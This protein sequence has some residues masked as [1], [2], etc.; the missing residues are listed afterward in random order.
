[1]ATPA[2]TRAIESTSKYLTINGCYGSYKTDTIVRAAKHYL[3]SVGKPVLF[4]T[5]C[6]SVTNEIKSRMENALSIPIR[7]QRDSSHYLGYY[8]DIPVCISNFDGWVHL[9]MSKYFPSKLDGIGDCHQ[10]KAET[11]LEKLGEL[12]SVKCVI[13]DNGVASRVFIDEAQDFDDVRMNIVVE[14]AKQHTDLHIT[15]AGDYLQTIYSDYVTHPITMF[16][17]LHPET[18]LLNTSFRCPFGHVQFNNQVLSNARLRYRIVDVSSNNTNVIDKP[19]LFTH[20]SVSKDINIL[21]ISSMVSCIL[22]QVMKHDKSVVPGDIAII[23][24]KTNNNKVYEHLQETLET[25]FTEMGFS[26]AVIHMSTK[27]K[28]DGNSLNWDKAQDKTVL[29]SIHGDK[30]KGH[31]LVIVLGAT[32]KSIPME[33]EIYNS[34]ELIADSLINVALSRSTKYLFVGF[35]NTA[36]TRYF[37]TQKDKIEDISYNTWSTVT[38]LPQPYSDIKTNLQTY[39]YDNIPIWLWGCYKESTGQDILTTNGLYR[40]KQMF[41]SGFARLTVSNDVVCDIEHAKYVYNHPWKKTCNTQKLTHTNIVLTTEMKDTH[42]SIMGTVV[43]IL[44]RRIFDK[45]ML[46]AFLSRDKIFTDDER[47]LCFMSDYKRMGRIDPE[48]ERYLSQNPSIAKDISQY[49][50]NKNAVVHNVFDAPIFTADLEEFCSVKGN[51]QLS[52]KCIWNVTLLYVQ[53]TSSYYMPNINIYFDYLTEDMSHI[54]DNIS[55]FCNTVDTSPTDLYFEE[56]FSIISITEKSDELE[57]LGVNNLHVNSIVGRYDMYD[58]EKQVLYE[59]KASKTNKYTERWLIQAL[60]YCMIM[61]VHHIPVK[62]V[63]IVNVIS[64]HVWSWTLPEIPLLETLVAKFEK[65]YYKW[66]PIEVKNLIARIA[67]IRTKSPS[68]GDNTC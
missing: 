66:H 64:G 33:S 10:E 51:A 32:E 39:C 46:C 54:H 34:K 4:L 9:M 25:T 16:Q 3:T 20:G 61:N 22:R 47:I 60:V 56:Q 36:P 31:K 6:A 52:T 17:S 23:M 11:L 18:I 1:M 58:A 49:I 44:I 45:N 57:T 67:A 5:K 55:T 28:Y 30:G 68:T 62:E 29:I 65:N 48:M 63:R 40:D 21:S 42:C 26:K 53:L 59:F 43:E 50:E 12:E 15:I 37:V 24:R 27:S 13:K 38:D 41:A 2:H 7:K 19:F 35:A 8:N 14:L